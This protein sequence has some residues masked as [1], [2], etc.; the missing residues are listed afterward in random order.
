M[1]GH[2]THLECTYCE[3]TFS[4]DEVHTTC[5][6][7]GKV[8]HARY[9]LGAA[10]R[11]LTRD[12]L[13]ARS[14]DMWRY[15]EVM[16][17]RDPV[18]VVSLGEGFTPVLR[19]RRL[20]ATVDCSR[21]FI[22]DEGL[23]PTGSFKARGL[24][25]AVSRARELGLSRFVIPSAGNAAGALAAYC[26]KGGME[27]HVFMPRDA[28]RANRTECVYHG[29]ELTLVDGFIDD[30]GRLAREAAAREA[31]AGEAVAGERSSAAARERT[32]GEG[33]T[34][35][36]GL[37]DVST[38]K[39][40]Y[41]VEGKK[42]MGYEIAEQMG[43]RLPD[44]IV[45]PTGGGTGIVGM[46]KAFAEMEELGWIGPERPR[47]ISVQAEGCAPLVRAFHDGA[48][49]AEPWESPETL[50]AGLRVPGAIGDYLVLRILRESSGTALAV[51]DDEILEGMWEVASL[52]GI[53]ACPEGAATWSAARVLRGRG[54]LDPD[55]TVLL[56]NTG[57]GLKYLDV[58]EGRDTS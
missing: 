6:A 32:S 9:D 1:P 23:N 41:R 15:G 46:W 19:A 51:S 10:A 36:G 5:P 8:L 52:E 7:C 37:F 14:P 54:L 12:D 45:Y 47:M 24:S 58:V 2:L 20:G 16:P 35:H 39:E 53:F 33:E 21:L 31:R 28:P 25:A 49:F 55:E 4:A 44:A 56:M 38:L 18:H 34:T 22:K 30:A 13:A 48:E 50:A 27:A 42:T 26:A 43:W 57:S 29:A 17:I 3:G 11:T 40:P